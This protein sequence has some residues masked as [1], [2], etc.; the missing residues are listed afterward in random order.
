MMMVRAG[1]PEV[2]DND[3]QPSANAAE[4]QAMADSDQM[5]SSEAI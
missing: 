2:I 5:L 4:F 1:S 3:I